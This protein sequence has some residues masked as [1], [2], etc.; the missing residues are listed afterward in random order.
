MWFILFVVIVGCLAA[1]GIEKLVKGDK[2]ATPKVAQNPVAAPVVAPVLSVP[3]PSASAAPL[4]AVVARAAPAALFAA[5]STPKVGFNVEMPDDVE[6]PAFLRASGLTMP[7]WRI[8]VAAR[9]KRI[10]AAAKAVA[11]KA[12]AKAAAAAAVFS[13][14]DCQELRLLMSSN[15]ED[16]IN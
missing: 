3:V 10:K 8:E 4:H 1:S 16:Y 9:G 11:T 5:S 14:E 6:S 12:A 15:V 7:Q 2:P 13:E